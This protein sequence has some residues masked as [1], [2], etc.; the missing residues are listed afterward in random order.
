MLPQDSETAVLSV[1]DVNALS[2]AALADFMKRNRRSDGVIELPVDD[3]NTLSKDER[4]H[5]AD[6]LM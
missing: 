3:W 6:R 5:L 1:E 4:R 2:D